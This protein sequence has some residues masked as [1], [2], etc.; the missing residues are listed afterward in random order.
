[1]VL[2][3]SDNEGRL[4]SLAG[5]TLKWDNLGHLTE[6][7]NPNDTVIATYTY[8]P[9]DRLVSKVVPEWAGD[10]TTTYTYVGLSTTVA[11]VSVAAGSTVETTAHITDPSGTD[12]AEAS[13][14]RDGSGNPVYGEPTYIGRNGHGD[15]VWQADAA[16]TISGTVAYDPFGAKL[17]VAGSI[18]TT[19][20]WQSSTFDSASGLYYVI[21]R[22]YSPTLGRFLS[23]D[24]LAGNGGSPQTLDRYAYGAGDSINRIDPDGRCAYNANTHRT[25]D[26]AG[27][28]CVGAAKGYIGWTASQAKK[29]AEVHQWSSCTVTS[30]NL[31]GC[32]NSTNGGGHWT[33]KNASDLTAAAAERLK[34]EAAAKQSQGCDPNPLSGNSCVGQAANTVNDGW[35]ATG[36]SL[37]DYAANHPLETGACALAGP[38]C[39]AL[40]T[41]NI[42]TGGGVEQAAN[43]A[44]EHPAVVA[45]VLGIALACGIPGVNAVAC[46]PVLIGAA[47]GLATYAGPK[48]AGN[49]LGGKLTL[50]GLTEGMN[51]D[52]AAYAALFG[53]VSF[54]TIGV[55]GSKTAPALGSYLAASAPNTA[56]ETAIMTGLYYTPAAAAAVVATGALDMAA[57]RTTARDLCGVMTS[58]IPG[59]GKSVMAGTV[60]GAVP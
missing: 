19:S 3:N 18:T 38:L 52:D 53:E 34:A 33:A 40:G 21:A 43:W 1:M 36:G 22:W 13:L 50:Q 45:A 42:V 7:G 12:L 41:A 30:N 14:S 26:T 8:D 29:M 32:Y 10:V 35:Q 57:G 11:A 6:V 2:Y 46:G 51:V 55:V 17:A 58:W 48:A 56:I 15:V 28:P 60:C 37:V 59:V 54:G 4:T 31:D 25:E 39:V 49:A 9:L 23:L 5:K 47:V 44:T 16:G 20:A 27:A 24:P